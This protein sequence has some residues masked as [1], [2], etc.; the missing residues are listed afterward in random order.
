MLFLN[1]HNQSIF[2]KRLLAF[3]FIPRYQPS[4][5]FGILPFEE[6]SREAVRI[7]SIAAS[8]NSVTSIHSSCRRIIT[9]RPTHT[10][11]RIVSLFLRT[12]HLVGNVSFSLIKSNIRTITNVLGPGSELSEGVK[13]KLLVSRNRWRRLGYSV[14]QCEF[15]IRCWCLSGR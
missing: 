12:R 7:R 15:Q 3:R 5:Y 10:H 9:T 2:P 13:D 1:I 14:G 11:Y 8:R 4:S 6:E